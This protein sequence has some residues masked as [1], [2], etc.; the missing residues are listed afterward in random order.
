MAE[1]KKIVLP[2]L[3]LRDPDAIVFPGSFF[4]AE[5]GRPFSLKAIE[6]ARANGNK[7]IIAMQKD[8]KIDEPNAKDFYGICTEAEITDV[9]ESEEEGEENFIKLRVMGI[10][11]AWLESIGT[12]KSKDTPYLF[13][14]IKPVKEPNFNIDEHIK[15]SIRQLKEMIGENLSI[16]S[17]SSKPITT[18]KDLSEFVDDIAFGLPVAGHQKLK[19]LRT[20]DPRKRL[21]DIITIVGELVKQSPIS[22]EAE[23]P[24]MGEG[25]S[26]GELARLQ[27]MIETAQLPAEAL[28]MANQ[29]LRR[30]K[31]MTPQSSEFHVTLNYVEWLASLPWKIRTKD[32]LDIKE[33]QKYLDADHYGLKKV[34]ERII[35]FLAVRKLAPEKMGTI[36]CFVGPPGTGKT[37]LGRSIAKAIGRKF[38]RMSLGG[39]HDEAE[40]RGH[41]RTYV[42]ALPGKI[43][44][45]IK[46]AN[47]RNPVFVLDEID[48][49]C[50]DFRGDPASALLEVLD[51][52]QNNTFTDNFLGTPF[53]LSDVMFIMTAN[54]TSPIPPALYDRMEVIEIPG[55]SPFDKVRIAQHHLIPKQKKQYGLESY[56]VSISPNAISRVIEEYTGEAGVRNLE[57]QCGTVMRKIAVVVASGKEPSS[58]IK[59]DMIPKFLGPPRIFAEKAL[60]APELG[61]SAGLAWSRHGG[62]ILFV[63]TSLTPGKGEIILT[64]NLGK[65]LQESAKAAH[66]WIKSNAGKLNID[67]DFLS[68]NDV[69]VHLPAGATP[70]D[71][72]SAGVAVASSM[73]SLFLGKPVRNDVA[74]TGEI[75]LRGRVLPIG[76]LKEKILAAHRAGI[77]EILYPKQNEADL[78]EIPTDVKNDIKLTPIKTLEEAIELVLVKE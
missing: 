50:K 71:G 58:T 64:G 22:I 6:M 76:G 28:A 51:P 3:P 26:G 54:E 35:E 17:I 69:H 60:E 68:S 29:E 33:A 75:T 57:R 13:G 24:G 42:G 15:N 55:Y 56:D 36:L 52:E 53:D 47:S 49:L 1:S 9:V 4:E 72:P 46:K 2:L 7:I 8:V 21:E 66:T 74:M 62:S 27:K 44:Q 12:K 14:H 77:K 73:L 41:R 19:L 5:V 59:V 38:V 23:P 18:S 30:L 20:K 48:K 39:V 34:K 45:N 43:I 78:E 40:I 70:K 63:E 16:I 10:R 61:V 32:S 67:M 37:S 25:G 65:V 31:M 11:R